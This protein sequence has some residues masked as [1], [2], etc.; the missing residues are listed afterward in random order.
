MNHKWINDLWEK[1]ERKLSVNAKEIGVHFPSHTNKQ[2]KLIEYGSD[3]GISSWTNGFWP[4]I[5]WLA[6]KETRKNIYKDIA[7]RCEEL[8]DEAFVSFKHLNHDV[9]FMWIPTSIFHYKE[10]GNEDSKN[11]AL[12]AATILAGRFNYNAK[13]IRAWNFDIPNWA[14][15]D[16]M[17]NIPLL[18]WA[19]EVENDPRYQKVAMMHADTALN[20]FIRPDGSVNHI[21]EF[22][23]ETGEVKGT[24]AGQ[25]YASGSSWSRGQAWAIYGFVLSYIKTGKVEYLDAA[26]KVAHYF[27]AN[28]DETG[29]ADV[30]FRAPKAEDLKDASAS[31]VAACGLIEL[32]KVVPEDEKELYLQWAIK[33]VKGIEKVCDFSNN[34]PLIVQHCTIKYHGTEYG[35]D[36]SLIYGD[37]YF[38]EA[39]L[40]L[41]GQD[42]FF[43]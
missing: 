16:C 33:I 34:T 3:M 15:I 41:K 18:Y 28:L 11:R 43:G 21:V 2:G 35:R 40:K 32:S 10:D 26:K 30:D 17:M 24:P 19:S 6:Y 12:H 9:G 1:I 25:G 31:A 22:D 39:V 38:I 36:I 42:V 20:T 27:I 14:I 5:M 37:Y 23:V 29:I 7:I 8:L 13:L 4:G